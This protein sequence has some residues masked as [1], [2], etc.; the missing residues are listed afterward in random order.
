M[1][2]KFQM[3]IKKGEEIRPSEIFTLKFSNIMSVFSH[4]FQLLLKLMPHERAILKV[5][6]FDINI[7]IKLIRF[8]IPFGELSLTFLSRS[9]LPTYQLTNLPTYQLTN[10]PTYQ[11]TNLPT[12]L[13]TNL[14]TNQLTNLPTYQ[15]TNLPTYQLT[16][17]PTYQLTNLP[18]Y[19]LTNL[20]T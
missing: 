7:K 18:T 2:V 5:I 10:L 12:N 16:N 20:P 3:S 8:S 11:L 19:Q 4:I 14:P 13:L 1:H 9:I 6:Y 17:L 15:L